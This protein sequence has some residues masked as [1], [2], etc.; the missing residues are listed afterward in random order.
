MKQ[1]PEDKF[2]DLVEK[3]VF[4][5]IEKMADMPDLNDPLSILLHKESTG[6]FLFSEDN[7]PYAQYY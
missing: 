2:K 3:P 6:E 5:P 1:I 4:V 7:G